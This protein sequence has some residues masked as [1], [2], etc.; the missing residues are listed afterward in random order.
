MGDTALERFAASGLT[1]TA[2]FTAR[3]LVRGDVEGEAAAHFMGRTSA[4]STPQSC[5][6]HRDRAEDREGS[7]Q[8]RVSARQE[9]GIGRF[10]PFHREGRVMARDRPFAP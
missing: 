2:T 8:R 1:A 4:G 7:D 10:L 5:R 6:S 9:A 3:G